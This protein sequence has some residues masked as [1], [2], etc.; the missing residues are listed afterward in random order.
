MALGFT[1]SMERHSPSAPSKTADSRASQ[2]PMRAQGGGGAADHTQLHQRCTPKFY[3]AC[4]IKLSTSKC[5]RHSASVRCLSRILP[6]SLHQSRFDLP[7]SNAGAWVPKWP[8]QHVSA[9][10]L[11]CNSGGCSG[12]DRCLSALS[13]SYPRVAA[14]SLLSP[15]SR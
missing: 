10:L 3:G 2:I 1:A 15:R 8:P 14:R 9:F 12:C 13:T 6:S 5:T 7:D 4:Q 11:R